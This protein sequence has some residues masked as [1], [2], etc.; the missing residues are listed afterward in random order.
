MLGVGADLVLG[1]AVKGLADQLEVVAQVAR[2]LRR[3][4][5]GQH[6]R[7]AL[8]AQE[9][10]RRRRPPRLHA[11]E[12]FPPRHPAHQLGDDVGDERGRD[13]SLDLP[14][15]A[16]LE[17][18]PGRGQRR[19]GVRHVIGDHLVGVD[20]PVVTYG[21]TALVDE[22]LGQ[23]DRPGGVVEHGSGGRRHG[24]RP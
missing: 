3:G 15:L 17:G 11:P 24:P 7:V 14:V 10:R 1:E 18:G 22:V 6:G 19:R 12:L 23:V 9:R 21:G 13:A 5:A 16:V 8:L 4:Q 20:P 2:A